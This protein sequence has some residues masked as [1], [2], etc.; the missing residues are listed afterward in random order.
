MRVRVRTGAR[1][2]FRI[3]FRFRFRVTLNGCDRVKL[4]VK[5]REG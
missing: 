2:R 4:R 3:W 1:D 5:G